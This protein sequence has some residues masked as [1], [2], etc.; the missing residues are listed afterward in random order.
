MEISIKKLT[1]EI[2]DDFLHFFDH[3]AFS[4]HEEWNGCYCLES[5]LSREENDKLWGKKNKRRKKAKSLIQEGIMTGYLIYDGSDVVGWCNA[6]DKADYYPIC[7]NKDFST[8]GAEKGKI[9]IIY[10][11]DIAANYRGRGLANYIVRQVLADAKKEGYLY[12]EAYPFTDKNF[13]YQ[14][15]GPVRLY[16]KHGFEIYRQL[17]RFYIMRKVL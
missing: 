1:P 8:V 9:K 16:E 15:R 7:E 17:E 10:C 14:Y 12:V 5:H 6:G 3:V 2:S 11:I 4:D 13:A